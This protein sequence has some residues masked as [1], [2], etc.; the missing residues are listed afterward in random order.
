M[1]HSQGIQLYILFL[2]GY[3]NCHFRRLYGRSSTSFDLTKLQ[4]SSTISPVSRTCRI[5]LALTIAR[6][7]PQQHPI[8]FLV[9]CVVF[10]FGAVC[11]TIVIMSIVPC[12]QDTA[13]ALGPPYVCFPSHPL[14]TFA[15]S[16]V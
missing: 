3:I 6:I 8:F 1:N 12:A 11:L 2:V 7:M 4:Q 16:G 5:S 15:L 9:L 10:F 13:W 14:G